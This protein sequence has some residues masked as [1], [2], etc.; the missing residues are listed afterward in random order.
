MSSAANNVALPRRRRVGAW[1]WPFGLALLFVA[2]VAAWLQWTEARDL[3]DEQ[4]TLITD[5]LT[6]QSR[7]I[8]IVTAERTA[9]AALAA[10][11][12][13][14][15]DDATLLRQGAVADGLRRLWISITLLDAS[16]RIAAHAPAQEKRPSLPV[17]SGGIDDGG[18]SAHLTAPARNGGQVIVRFS[19]ALL[20]RQSMPWWLARRYE[21]RLVDSA[22]QRLA[23]AA[24]TLLTAGRRQHLA[25]LEPELND[26]WLEL[27][28]RDARVPWW[29]TLPLLL[30]AVFLVLS[31]AATLALRRHMREVEAAEERW[32]NEAAWRRAIED[33]LTVG[34]RAR[35]LEGR[36]VHVNR[37][38]CELV[39]LAPEA[40]L[41]RLPPMPYWPADTSAANMERHRRNMA[42]RAPRDGYEARW[43]RSDGTPLD[44]MIFEAPLVD[45]RGQHIG[46][47]GSIVDI[48]ARK[49]AEER[50]RRHG[51]ALATQAR[52]TTLGEVASALA[53][54][55]NQPLTAITSYNA[56]V[57]RTLEGAGY[58]DTVVLDALRRLGE[59]AAE[60]GRVVQRIRGFLTRRSPQRESCAV[61]AIAARVA[62]LLRRDLART[63][64]ELTLDVPADLPAVF[65]DPVLIEQVLINLVRN[66]V[67]ELHGAEPHTGR[68]RI[69]A[70]PAGD[71]FVRIDVD[72]NGGGLQGR[73][74]QQLTTPFY[75][76]KHEGMGMGLAICRSVIEAHYGAMEASAAALGGA[77]LS[78][79]LPVDT[80]STHA[81]R[82]GDA[83]APA[84]ATAK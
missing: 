77:R 43:V 73:T 28:T 53:H 5:S 14:D 81:A 1:A 24:E 13:P 48:T 80:G 50:E 36:L 49:Q 29:R 60:A 46:W 39:G 33:S 9:I 26:T 70:Q 72:D 22:G 18:I 47:M 64:V 74:I 61:G 79:T 21:A 67:D 17:V 27:T 16:N 19:P 78:F 3:E 75:S 83:V 76:T 10:E 6:V 37:A 63:G 57:L 54:Q 12:P 41:G 52:L 2:A 65:V 31:A 56:G 11:L 42:G 59:Q 51:E 20:L 23:G 68:V 66:A 69:A 4:R 82:A 44:V 15:A 35:D 30:M 25:S 7:L 40:L 62:Q 71:R 58:A 34:L 55:L 84:Q 38:F 8:D 32:R 45:A